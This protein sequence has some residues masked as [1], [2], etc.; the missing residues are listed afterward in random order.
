MSDSKTECQQPHLDSGVLRTWSTI[1]KRNPHLRCSFISGLLLTVGL[2]SLAVLAS[3]LQPTQIGALLDGSGTV[4]YESHISAIVLLG[5]IIVVASGIQTFVV[6]RF[7]TQLTHRVR[8]RVFSIAVDRKLKT[9]DK[10]EAEAISARIVLDVDTAVQGLFRTIPSLLRSILLGLLCFTLMFAISGSMSLVVLLICVV[11]ATVLWSVTSAYKKSLQEMLEK[12]GWLFSYTIAAL[13]SWIVW[14]R[15]LGFHRMLER[16]S[17]RSDEYRHS[18][19]RT[20][21]IQVLA[22]QCVGLLLQIGQLFLL[23]WAFHLK[24]LG[25][26][27][28]GI[29]VTFLIYYSLLLPEA[30][31]SVSIWQ[32]FQEVKSAL[33]RIRT[34]IEHNALTQEELHLTI[35]Q[36]CEYPSLELKELVV[37]VGDLSEGFTTSPVSVTTSAGQML[38]VSG[39]SGCGKTTLLHGIA[40]LAP[41]ISGKLL[42]HLPKCDTINENV[43]D[44]IEYFD[45]RVC[46][47]PENIQLNL[48]FMNMDCDDED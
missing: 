40:G 23:L 10:V 33:E 20:I 31:A 34:I 43:A 6:G 16:Y 15:S 5:I 38:G 35:E 41:I 4:G 28:G 30:T 3:A 1:I 27:T 12:R 42:I 44:M 25:S 45:Q 46:L 17:V 36:D 39:P 13:S 21:R 18:A 11:V 7:V 48:G 9:V 32:G 29:L 22:S 24:S 2:D 26:I 8:C 47:T 14:A 19:F 37:H